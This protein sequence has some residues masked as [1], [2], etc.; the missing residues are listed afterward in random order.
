MTMAKT[1]IRAAAALLA[2]ASL[3]APS[4]QA[5]NASAAGPVQ[6]GQP[7]NPASTQNPRPDAVQPRTITLT[8][9][10]STGR[11]WFPNI[12]APYTPMKMTAPPLTNSPEIGQLIRDGNLMLSLQDAIS[13][14]LENN[15]VIDVERYVPWL[16]EVSLLR[17]TSGINGPISFDPT[18][19]GNLNL[20]NAATPLNNPLFAGVLPTSSG[21]PTVTAPP[22][23]E[24][25]LANMNFQYNQNFPT[26]TQLQMAMTNS[27]TST[28]FGSFN[29][30]NPFLQSVL[31]VTLTQPLLRGFGKLPNTRLI[32][33][34]RR[35]IRVG[36]SQ[37]EQQ[38]IATTTQVS[39][40]YWELVYA[41]QNVKVRETAV[42]VSQRLYD[43][44]SERLKIGTLSS[45]DVLTAESQLA[46][47][48]QSLVQAQSVQL[49][50]ETTLL[51]DI[52]KNP[53]DP[54]LLHA[55][56]IP[57][58]AIT[59][60][61]TGE[62]IRIEDAVNE[63]WQK[64]PELKQAALNLENA[65]TDVAASRNEL[66]PTVN[67]VGQYSAA[68]L[69]GLQNATGTS[70]TGNY[71]AGLPVVNAS[72]VPVAGLFQSTALTTNT[73]VVFPGGVGQ[74]L[75]RVFRGAYSTFEGGINFTLPIRN[76]AAQADNA[77][78]LLNQ[79][80]QKVQYRQEQNTI[81]LGVRNALIAMQ[82]DRASLAAAEEATKL[83]VQTFEDESEKYR[84]GA[85]TSYNV[86]LRSRDV[87]AA[88]GTELRDRINLLEDELKFNQEMGRTLDI[89]QI[90]VT[91]V[92]KNGAP[93]SPNNP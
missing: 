14:A 5:Q 84:L 48:K 29:L 8:T 92:L 36:L 22:V 79:R 11:K 47:D 64:R 72:G 1:R 25:H 81:L 20:E 76:R 9:N 82:E 66:K 6:Q 30:Y 40:D 17:A 93:S 31:T 78:A 33:E 90:S 37:L 89:N 56:I 53:L 60:P 91:D 71:V 18:L 85:S 63:A 41:R 57:T 34:A 27:R 69:G 86:V 75:S 15:L 16:N 35:N 87:T 77:Q 50:D 21:V 52:A 10:Y 43:E 51:N 68:G 38:V 39:N 28:N 45:L 19:T 65:G 61:D 26:G 88:E 59:T 2:I 58:T 67:L 13:L 83:A 24:Q 74:D 55:E 46:S 7:S 23:Y 80:Q 42:G 62:N 70:V 4:V 54:T 12:L 44:N 32:V 73:S 49:Q 3:Y